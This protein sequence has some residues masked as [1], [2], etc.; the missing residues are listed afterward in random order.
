LE[1][2]KKRERIEEKR[3]KKKEENEE[4]EDVGLQTHG[5]GVVDPRL[6]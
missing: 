1:C 3:K 2:Q 6:A 4:E 5:V